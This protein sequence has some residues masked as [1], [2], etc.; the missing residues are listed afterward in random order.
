[1]DIDIWDRQGE[2]DNDVTLPAEQ[3][4]ELDSIIPLIEAVEENRTLPIC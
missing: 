4:A 3:E 1:M 2:W